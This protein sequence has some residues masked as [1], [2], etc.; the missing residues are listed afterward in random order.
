MSRTH[1]PYHL[2]HGSVTTPQLTVSHGFIVLTTLKYWLFN[3]HIKWLFKKTK[4][5]LYIPDRVKYKI[6]MNLTFKV[7]L[8][9]LT[10]FYQRRFYPGIICPEYY[11]SISTL[12]C[13]GT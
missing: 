8:L 1:R 3:D 11:C 5:P 7:S 13:F 6:R 9:K 4:E 12:P 2:H 10:C